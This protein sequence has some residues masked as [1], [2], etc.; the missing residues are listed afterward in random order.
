MRNLWRCAILAQLILPRIASSQ[1]PD[2]TPPEPPPGADLALLGAW[3]ER[4]LPTVAAVSGSNVDS[5]GD[6]YGRSSDSVMAARL[7]GCTLVLYERSV[8]IVRGWRS[9]KYLTIYVPL[10]QVDTAMVQPKIRQAR[11]LLNRP[12]VL[13]SGQLVVPL[14]NRARMEFI[15]VVAADGDPQYPMLVSE[16]DVPFI[17]EELPAAHSALALRQAAA[18]CGAGGGGGP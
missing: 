4:W 11:L 15:T 16:Y 1:L 3:I 9:A 13:L 18:R 2:R 14:R 17:F 12:N 10:E 6:F 7:D 8:S 5:T